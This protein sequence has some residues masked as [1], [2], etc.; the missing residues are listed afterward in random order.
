MDVDRLVERAVDTAGVDDFGEDTWQEGLSILV[1]GLNREAELNDV[2]DAVA[3][4]ELLAYLVNR[5]QVL[6]WRRQHPEVAGVAITRPIF[7]VGQPRTGTTILYDLLAQDSTNRVPLTWEVDH[8][9]PPPRTETYGD[10]PRIATSQAMADMADQII[11]GFTAFHPIG[12]QLAQECVRIMGSDFRSMIFPVQYRVLRYNRWLIHE[13]D[14]AS[15]YRWHRIFLEHLQSGH[16]ADRWLLKSPAHLWYL[17][18]LLAEYP[19]ALVI[20]THRDPL[21]VVASVS[22]LTAHL[23]Q[24]ASDHHSIAE[25]ADQYCDDIF[26]GLERSLDARADGTLPVEQVVDVQFADFT[27]DPFAT[28][29]AIYDRL[30]LELTD[31]ADQRMRTFLADHPGDGGGGGTRYTWADTGL[32]SAALRE[33]ARPYQ[34]RFDVPSEP[35][36]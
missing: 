31:D 5:L 30:G 24:M 4:T 34:E 23:R 1:D 15:T 22:A 25:A 26:V 35:V 27:A 14:M 21:K 7:I 28:I 8:P 36:A 11:P 10:D 2:G 3:E 18:A 19:D 16:M 17:P 6:E 33:R 13:T 9:C 29:A 12:A 32:D 20:Q